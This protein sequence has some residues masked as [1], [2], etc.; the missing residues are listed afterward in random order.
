MAIVSSDSIRSGKPVIQGTRVAV[1]DIV[2]TFYKLDR[3]VEEVAEDF[4]LDVEQVEEALRYDRDQISA[5][6]A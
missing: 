2:E 5:I 6:E 4:D 1:E 3:S